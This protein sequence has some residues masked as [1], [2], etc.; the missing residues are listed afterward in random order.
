M[1]DGRA[2]LELFAAPAAVTRCIGIT[3]KVVGMESWA[4]VVMVVLV[5]QSAGAASVGPGGA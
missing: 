1:G 5:R 3:R 2:G 4:W